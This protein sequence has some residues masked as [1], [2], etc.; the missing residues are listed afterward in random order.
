MSRMSCLRDGIFQFVF[1]EADCLQCVSDICQW[2]HAR[3][4]TIG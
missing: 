2:I 1:G 4:S 3:K